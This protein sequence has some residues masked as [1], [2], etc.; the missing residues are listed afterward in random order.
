M[1]SVRVDP[2]E[3]L[4]SRTPTNGH[5]PA[6]SSTQSQP[7]GAGTFESQHLIESGSGALVEV[8]DRFVV[9]VVEGGTLMTLPQLMKHASG[10]P[11]SG[12]SST[13]DRMLRTV[14]VIGAQVTA[15]STSI[16]ASRVSTQTGRRPA[17]GPRSAQ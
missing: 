9:E 10:S 5:R 14:R 7:R 11:C 2:I 12:P 6:G 16:A 8:A 17:G 3:P 13:S 15:L 4:S 1:V